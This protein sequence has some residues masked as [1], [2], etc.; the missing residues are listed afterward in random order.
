MSNTP[1]APIDDQY[2][3]L[4]GRALY[5]FA[6]AEW[7]IIY[8][9]SLLLPGFLNREAGNDSHTIAREFSLL[10]QGGRFPELVDIANRFTIAEEKR[11][12]FLRATPITGP[13]G[14]QILKDSGQSQVQQWD[15]Q[16]VTA[17]TSE[18]ETLATYSDV[19][20]YK[21]KPKDGH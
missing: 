8:L 4:I 12:E 7:E 3:A 9:G 6:Y 15:L 16:T 5:N 1:G 19:L 14:A 13:L 20:Y 10:S 21:L 11:M 18:L 2:V 17:F